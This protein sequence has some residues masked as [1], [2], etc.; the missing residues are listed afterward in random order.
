MRGSRGLPGHFHLDRRN[1]D[2]RNARVVRTRQIEAASSVSTT[3]VEHSRAL[4]NAGESRQVLSELLLRQLF[5]FVA[6]NPI[7]MMQMFAPKRAV[8]GTDDVVVLDDF[9]LVVWAL[10]SAGF[11]IHKSRCHRRG[12]AF[13]SRTQSKR[14]SHHLAPR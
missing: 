1:R 14:R 6:P 5:G 11:L 9:S 12:E 4:R 10:Q 3:N 7:T 2:A 13:Y 8:I